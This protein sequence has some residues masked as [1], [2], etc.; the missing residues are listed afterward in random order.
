MDDCSE[1]RGCLCLSGGDLLCLALEVAAHNISV[2][3]IAMDINV[4]N[5]FYRLALYN[6]TKTVYVNDKHKT[7]FRKCL[8]KIVYR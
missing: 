7:Q 1:T 3:V 8:S 2:H 6:S 5:E 4:K